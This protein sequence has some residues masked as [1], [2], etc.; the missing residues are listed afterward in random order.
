MQ[1]QINRRAIRR[2]IRHRIRRKISGTPSRPRLAIYRSLKHIYAQVIDDVAGKT[3]A[4]AS[5][6]QAAIR[7][8][9]PNGGNSAAATK[10]GGVIGEQLKAAGIKSVVFDRGGF[11]Y[12]GRIKALAEAVREAGIKL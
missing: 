10:V 9:C 7:S 4:H 3:L 12:H 2:R 1:V 5:T 11:V 8:D 6:Q